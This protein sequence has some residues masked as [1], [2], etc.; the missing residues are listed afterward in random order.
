MRHAESRYVSRDG[1]GHGVNVSTFIL[2]LVTSIVISYH[3]GVHSRV[4]LLPSISKQ[5]PSN[6]E[7]M[8]ANLFESLWD[9]V[10]ILDHSISK[11][12]SD[13]NDESDAGNF[14][15]DRSKKLEAPRHFVFDMEAVPEDLICSM[16]K[17]AALLEEVVQECDTKVLVKECYS[18]SQTISCVGILGDRGHASLHVWP[19]SGV[20]L[21][22]VML[23]DAR[24][25]QS[26]EEIYAIFHPSMAN[27]FDIDESLLSSDQGSNWY[28]QTRARSN[29]GDDYDLD[30]AV[31][32]E[33]KYKVIIPK[34]MHVSS[35]G[36]AVLTNAFTRCSEQV[37]SVKT[38]FQR[39][40][41]VDVRAIPELINFEHFKIQDPDYIEA[42]PHL[43]S[44]D[45]ALYL[46]GIVQSTLHGN[47]AYHEALVQPSMFAHPN[48]KRVAIIGGGECATLREVLKHNTVEKVVMVE[49]D[50]GVIEVSKYALPMWNDCSHFEG[51]TRYC[52]DDQRAEI[53]NEDA[54]AWFIDRYLA[55][56]STEEET[57]FDV[58]IMDAL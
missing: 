33:M 52:M 15:E 58:I 35:S 7:P 12:A 42:N 27:Y 55:N 43:F 54:F 24:L 46:D 14:D 53:H 41:V 10:K 36:S 20:V 34:S 28:I 22:D 25:M 49:I 18:A 9:D 16:A 1:D 50:R 23:P 19:G 47:A 48:P 17:V 11:N 51:S 2:T 5:L 56:N 8:T 13:A 26:I 57:L 40:D 3:L 31:H 32:G 37:A 4:Y 39:V 29:Y 45:R 44:A 6:S 21:F 30:M 38:E